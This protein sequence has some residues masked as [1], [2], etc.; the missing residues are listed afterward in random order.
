ML[1]VRCDSLL[2]LDISPT[3]LE[4]ARRRRP[5]SER[6][7]FVEFDLRHNPIP[8]SFDLIVIAGV[9]EY[10][11]RLSTFHRTREKLAAALKPGGYLMVETTRMAY[12]IG[13]TCWWCRTM[14]VG[15]WINF[16]IAKH[17]SLAVIHSVE[18][19]DYVITVYRKATQRQSGSSMF[20]PNSS[21]ADDPGGTL[22]R[23]A[24]HPHRENSVA[25]DDGRH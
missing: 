10:F 17:S 12:P 1:A 13:D 20:P 7:R 3:A 15:K 2:V 24:F 21:V 11:A 14:I 4:R 18:T 16:F 5:W 9:L 22:G 19:D 6:I 23:A 25:R 8:G